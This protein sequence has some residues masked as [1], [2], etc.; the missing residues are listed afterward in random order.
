MAETKVLAGQT[1]YEVDE[2]GEYR[3]ITLSEGSAIAV[4][5]S[6]SGPLT[7]VAYGSTHHTHKVLCGRE[8]I[9]RALGV[10]IEEAVEA[11][12]RLFGEAGEDPQLSQLMDLLDRAGERYAYMGWTDA[13][14]A[15]IRPLAL[16]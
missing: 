12:V 10:A 1:L 13:G 6:S 15:V 5:E 8:A 9:A 11:L 3:R 16:V 2:G 7:E 14:D 4:M